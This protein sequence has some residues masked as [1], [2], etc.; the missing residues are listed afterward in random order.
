MK[1]IVLFLFAVLLLT[2]WTSTNS[3]ARPQKRF[4]KGAQMCRDFTTMPL[5]WETETWG[6]GAKK[7]RAVC[8]SCHTRDNIKNIPFVYEESHTSKGWNRFFE[9]KLAKCARDGSWDQLSAEDIRLVNDY[10]YRNGDWTYDPNDAD[11]CG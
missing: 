1:R 7:F 4:D 10:L 3:E 8:K 9:K 5:E 11:T 2:S 6:A